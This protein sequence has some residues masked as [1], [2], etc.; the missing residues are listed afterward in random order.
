MR[1]DQKL[2]TRNKTIINSFKY[3]VQR[4]SQGKF[5]R[6]KSKIRRHGRSTPLDVSFATEVR[7]CTES[8]SPG[9]EGSVPGPGDTELES[10]DRV[11]WLNEASRDLLEG[12]KIFAVSRPFP[13]FAA[14]KCSNCHPAG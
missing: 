4:S 3:R 9:N 14:A 2:Q 13:R 11:P 5:L 12:G 1:S 10:G 8:E 6:R 7:A